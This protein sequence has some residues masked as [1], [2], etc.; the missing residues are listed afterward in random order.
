MN[1]FKYG[2]HINTDLLFPGKYTYSCSTP[3]EIRPHLFEDLDPTF[4]GAVESGD[5]VMGGINFGC[6]SSREQPVLGLKAVGVQAVPRFHELKRPS[7]RCPSGVDEPLPVVA[8]EVAAGDPAGSAARLE[9]RKLRRLAMERDPGNE[10]A[11][12][13]PT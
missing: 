13:R 4:A 8:I 9:C 2:D 5:L 10:A 7:R 3:E 1:V 12:R 6:G 11:L